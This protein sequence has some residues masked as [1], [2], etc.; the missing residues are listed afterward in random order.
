MKEIDFFPNLTG[1]QNL[2]GSQIACMV[3]CVVLFLVAYHSL[4]LV[5]YACTCAFKYI[6]SIASHVCGRGNVFIVSVC[7]C[8]CVCV[9]LCVRCYAVTAGLT[10]PEKQAEHM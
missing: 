2:T 9:C 10:R 8:M 3:D 7:V 1:C 6:H 4:P 5:K